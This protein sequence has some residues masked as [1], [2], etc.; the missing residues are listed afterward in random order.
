MFGAQGRPVRRGVRLH[1]SRT[2]FPNTQSRLSS[3]HSASN[4]AWLLTRLELRDDCRLVLVGLASAGPSAVDHERRP[5][6]YGP[7]G[8]IDRQG[9]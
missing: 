6:V 5:R 4:R 3:F 9:D 8:R 2:R 1:P 7:G